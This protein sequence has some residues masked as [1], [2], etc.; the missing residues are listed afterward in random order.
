ML[1]SIKSAAHAS[2][3]FARMF[4]AAAKN[5]DILSRI[6][7]VIQERVRP[8]LK[9]DGG[10]IKIDKYEDGVVD[11]TLL[12][13]CSGCPSRRATLHDGILGCLQE[14]IPEIKDIRE[15]MVE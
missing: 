7:N 14:E 15:T 4:A 5:S 10:D 6:E 3:S 13:H 2:I 12:G 1:A 11:V 9:L 8:V